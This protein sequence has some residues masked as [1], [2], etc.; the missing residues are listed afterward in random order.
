MIIYEI[1]K[2]VLSENFN[3][4]LQVLTFTLAFLGIFE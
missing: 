2:A 3:Q 4:P 1:K